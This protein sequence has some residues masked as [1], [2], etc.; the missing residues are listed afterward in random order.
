MD[1]VVGGDMAAMVV[2]SKVNGG[3]GKFGSGRCNL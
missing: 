2:G 3:G 1:M